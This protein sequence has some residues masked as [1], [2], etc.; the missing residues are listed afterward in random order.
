MKCR[1]CGAENREDYT[2]CLMC[3]KPLRE[4]EKGSGIRLNKKFVIAAAAILVLALLALLL[5]PR[6]N[7]GS[8][9]AQYGERPLLFSQDGKVY[10]LSTDR[11]PSQGLEVTAS[12]SAYSF[13][14]STLAFLGKDS[15]GN[16]KLYVYNDKG[17]NEVA[18]KVDTFFLSKDG[19]YV[20]YQHD[21]ENG[22]YYHDVRK[23]KA[24]EFIS[25][26]EST[27]RTMQMSAAGST[28]AWVSY[29]SE[30]TIRIHRNGKTNS[31]ETGKVGSLLAVAPDDSV[32]FLSQE[33]AF[34]RLNKGT[35][36]VICEAPEDIFINDDY[37]EYAVFASGEFFLY[38]NGKVLTSD[39]EQIRKIR[40]LIYPDT[41]PSSSGRSY[42]NHKYVYYYKYGISSFT[43]S[44][45]LTTDSAVIYIDDKLNVKEVAGQAEECLISDDGRK[46]IY[47]D[48]FGN[49]FIYGGKDAQQLETGD[50]PC[51]TLYDY[52]RVNGGV[53]Y[54]SQN[55]QLVYA[56]S[57]NFTV[58][59]NKGSNLN[60]CCDD[61]YFYFKNGYTLYCTKKGSEPAEVDGVYTTSKGSNEN[62]TRKYILYYGADK[63]YYR[64]A[65][66]TR[67]PL[68][69]E[70]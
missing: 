46:L 68:K 58:V 70:P 1:Y 67:T 52:D 62:Y 13:D 50:Q 16:R 10:V 20:V 19:N 3:G 23:G 44:Y 57:K 11:K 24:V 64:A 17:L 31:Y 66:G 15:D 5:W 55:S 38:R 35:V 65:N 37:S 47:S 6:G 22:W 18:E 27:F 41:M 53:Y 32:Y 54:R 60:M 28:L 59:T 49:I 61:G 21:D 30:D 25:S 7:R 26:S 29:D 36:T 48:A 69:S 39:D 40:T 45:Y 56:D 43:S 2:Y 9:F 42:V 63:K 12:S 8:S 34:C 51:R 4:K 33:G 14:K